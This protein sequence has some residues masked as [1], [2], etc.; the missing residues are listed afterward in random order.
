MEIS[1]SH[2]D[3]MEQRLH[4]GF[5]FLFNQSLS[6]L[7]LLKP[8]SH[9]STFTTLPDFLHEY[10]FSFSTTLS[11]KFPQMKCLI[12]SACM[13]LLLH[14][15]MTNILNEILSTVSIICQLSIF[16]VTFNISVLCCHT[17][18]NYKSRHTDIQINMSNRF[19]LLQVSDQ[20][21]SDLSRIEK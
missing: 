20:C 2:I 8:N 19:M 13:C 17:V 10:Y 3:F 14:S 6:L 18:L 16:A 1:E 4:C 7:L 9:F 15:L 21:F 5:Y 12:S 11:F